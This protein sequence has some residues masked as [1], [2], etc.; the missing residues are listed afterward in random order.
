MTI[1]IVMSGRERREERQ[2]SLQTMVA[3]QARDNKG[4]KKGSSKVS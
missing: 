3:V 2:T 4:L 1:L